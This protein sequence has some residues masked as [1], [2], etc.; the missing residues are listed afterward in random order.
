MRQ[1]HSLGSGVFETLT[2]SK[3]GLDFVE[4]GPKY[5]IT[6]EGTAGHFASWCHCH[7]E[8]IIVLLRQICSKFPLRHLGLK[9]VI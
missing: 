3:N 6:V 2:S 5:D 9:H 1:M 7:F 4:K 8:S